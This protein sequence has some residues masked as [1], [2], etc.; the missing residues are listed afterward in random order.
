MNM[1][2]TDY[3]KKV[4]ALEKELKEA[5]KNKEWKRVCF[6]EATIA[7]YKKGGYNR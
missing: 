5:R 3:K 4:P 1:T 6:L 2:P 7:I